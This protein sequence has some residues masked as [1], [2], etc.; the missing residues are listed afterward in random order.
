MSTDRESGSENEIA[1]S[2]GHA[3]QPAAKKDKE[4]CLYSVALLWEHTSRPGTVLK[5]RQRYKAKDNADCLH[6]DIKAQECLA[7]GTAIRPSA[8]G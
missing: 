4:L 3:P 7:A 2:G 8:R 5:K 1:V 6:R